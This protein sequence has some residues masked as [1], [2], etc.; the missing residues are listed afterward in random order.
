MV[1]AATESLAYDSDAGAASA[2]EVAGRTTQN[3]LLRDGASLGYVTPEGR[4]HV[5]LGAFELRDG[6]A[7]RYHTADGYYDLAAGRWVYHVRDYLGT[8]RVTFTDADGDGDGEVSFE[9]AD[10]E[11]LETRTLYPFGAYAFGYVRDG[12]EPGRE[13]FTGHE[14]VGREANRYHAV[15]D[16]GARHYSPALGRFLGV[17]PLADQ[18]PADNPYHYVHGDPVNLT[19]PTG[20][21]AAGY[22]QA[23]GPGT[24]DFSQDEQREANFAA[25]KALA[26]ASGETYVNSGDGTFVREGPTTTIVREED[27]GTYTVTGGQIDGSGRSSRR[28]G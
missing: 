16:M 20:M 8:P 14:S 11:I 19:D 3:L 21:Y 12:Y 7:W 5:S 15:H 24:R 9:L 28:A 22:A 17:D 2:V 23:G 1:R 27:D 26:R 4:R 25:A 6:A 18:F 10:G 13:D